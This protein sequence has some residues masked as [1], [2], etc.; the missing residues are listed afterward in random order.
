MRIGIDASRSTAIQRTGT[1]NYTLYLV[2]A[3]L[4]LAPQ[5]HYTLYFNQPP[6]AD[7]FA[8]N[9]R[10]IARVLPSRRLWTHFTLGAE[11]RRDPPDVLF[12]PAHV[13]PLGYRGASV[14]TVH[15]VGYRHYPQAHPAL[16]RAYL[17]WSTRHNVRS[18]R[19]VVADSHATR[20]DLAH[21]YGTPADK[22][23][24]A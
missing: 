14:V 21:F 7:L 15:D 2:R 24:V 16:Q 5:H 17:D 9:E 19:M 10:V 22:V 11:L 1:E 13:I 12:V 8:F 23:V 20:R 4:E 6:A 18:A 3:L